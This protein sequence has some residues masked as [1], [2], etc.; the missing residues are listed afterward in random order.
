MRSCLFQLL[1]SA[2]VIFVLLWFGLPFGASWLATNALNASGFTGTDTKVEVTSN[3]PPMLLTGRA[4]TIRVTSTQVGVSDLHA[5]S[6]DLTLGKVELLTR[7]VGTVDGT[8]QGV[9]VASP[10]GQPI[11]IDKVTLSG[12]AR[13]ANAQ[14]DVSKAE[15]QRLAVSQLKA[16]GIVAT[17]ALASPDKV[18]ITA[19]GRSQTGHLA[20]KDGSLLLVP[21]GNAL[22]MVA[23]IA[24][25]SG[26]PFQISSASIGA[27][28]LTLMGTIDVQSLLGI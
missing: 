17:V 1:L 20:V 19:G 28:H 26:N 6:L 8:L 10:D 13:S 27:E 18:T 11:N 7:N 24:P 16:H 23:L 4:D 2:A 14:M 21:D 22:P 15:V 25:G 12:D 9:R 5:A 3:P